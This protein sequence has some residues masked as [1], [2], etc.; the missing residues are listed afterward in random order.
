MKQLRRWSALAGLAL[1][2]GLLSTLRGEGPPEKEG[3]QKPAEK[4]LVDRGLAVSPAPAPVPAF[5][6]R[7]FPAVSERKDGNAVPMYL[8]FAHERSDARK[9][10]LREKPDEW[11]KLPLEKLPLDEVKAF[12][13]GYKYNFRQLELG[14]RRKTAEWSYSLDAGD[15]IGLL[16][17]DVQEMR[18][19]APLLVLKARAEIA[20]RRYADAVRTLETGLSFS[21]Q[22]GNGPFLI[23]SLVGLACANQFIDGLLDLA[24][25]PDAPNLYWAL[26]VLPRPLVSLRGANEW[27]QKMLEMQFPDMADLDRPRSAEEWDAALVRVRKEV[28]RITRNDPG[29]GPNAA[30]PKFPAPTEPAAKSPDLPAARKYLAEVAGMPAAAVEAM[31]PAQ[32]LLLYL[33]NYYHEMRDEVF[34]ATYLPLPQAPRVIRATDERL[35]SC[36]D[37]EAGWVARLF[38]PAVNKVQ[39]AGGRIERRL[40]AQRAI[41]A[42]RL[43]AARDGR[44][45]EK[46]DEVTVVPVPDDPGTGQPFEYRCDGAT[47]T[48]ISR[49]PGEPVE[50]TGLRYRVTLRK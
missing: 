11:N 28:E 13:D 2:V 34:K 7:L 27:E 5:K 40:A 31:P 20:E 37:T 41:E 12:L 39:L 6:Y 17:P 46:L 16:L 30:R 32:V 48:L 35:K 50:T 23:Q 47:A 18:M 38:L 49:I 43:H 21:Q 45:P 4:W 36:P 22:V 15:P 33:A 3:A 9:K 42:L 10:L 26:A 14:A 29:E 8:R 25:R 24:E 19:Q 1:A 44:L